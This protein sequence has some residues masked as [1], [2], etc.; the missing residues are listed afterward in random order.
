MTF[1][2]ARTDKEHVQK[3]GNLL[4]QA[5]AECDAS[6]RQISA[7]AAKESMNRQNQR[8]NKNINFN[9]IFQYLFSLVDFSKAHGNRIKR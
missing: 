1:L 2:F 4:Q 9:S 7:L 5:H 8:N 6:K 3:R